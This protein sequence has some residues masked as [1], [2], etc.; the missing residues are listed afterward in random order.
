MGLRTTEEKTQKGGLIGFVVYRVT[1][2]HYKRGFM[3]AVN[4]LNP[5]RLLLSYLNTLI[6]NLVPWQDPLT[7]KK[8]MWNLKWV[9]PKVIYPH[10]GFFSL[11]SQG[12]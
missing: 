7:I 11:P 8:K 12:C 9:C 6:H 5:A 4:K 10:S 2:G 1:N 3:T